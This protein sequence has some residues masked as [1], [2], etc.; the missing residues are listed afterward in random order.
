MFTLYMYNLPSNAKKLFL[1]NRWALRFSIWQLVVLINCWYKDI[2]YI[3]LLFLIYCFSFDS[4]V[5]SMKDF[6]VFDTLKS[7]VN[8]KFVCGYRVDFRQ[9][10]SENHDI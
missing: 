1:F 3:L 2:C 10:V 8:P 5:I 9:K 7:T 6:C 4:R